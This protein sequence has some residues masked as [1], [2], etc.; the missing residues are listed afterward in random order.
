MNKYARPALLGLLAFGGILG[1]NPSWAAAGSLDPTFGANGV[2]VT[3]M[4][5]A[6]SSTGVLLYSV[7]LQSDGKI[8][9][10][11]NVT[12]SSSAGSTVAT[13]VLR[14]TTGGALDATFG[15]NGVAAIP[16]TLG[17]IESMAVQPNGQI[18]VA[19]VGS[20][21]LAVERLNPNGT[22]DTAFGSGG[23]ALASLNGRF[24]APQIVVL[25]Q[26]DGSILLGGQLEPAGRGQSAQTLLA[27]FTPV[28]A[29][30]QAFGNSGTVVVTGSGGCTTLALLSTGDFQV[31]DA[32]NIAQFTSAGVLEPTS[33]GG[34]VVVSA[35]SQNPSAASVMQPNGD[36]LLAGDVFVG[37]ESRGHNAAAQVL[38]FTPSGTA[39][40]SFATPTFHYSGPGGSGIEAIPHALAVQANGDIVVAGDQTTAT[41]T[42]TVIVNGLARLTPSGN[43][44]PS[45]GNGGTVAN[46]IPAGTEGFA[47]VVIQPTDG[48]IVV[49]GYANNSTAVTVSRYLAQ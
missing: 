46:S 21:A 18:L 30:D 32:F 14:Y 3:T 43:L 38:R 24:P 42:G 20:G 31:V 44:D 27:R 47:G 19:G 40:T 35:G 15:R 8:L 34:T 5:G 29:L 17:E 36:Y 10:L 33:T 22:V 49:I 16:A 6:S 37:R 7:K 11:A 1:S 12:S 48:K 39:D 4:V 28:G 2:T 41:T 26:P 45:F 23:M 13:D 9:V 25:A